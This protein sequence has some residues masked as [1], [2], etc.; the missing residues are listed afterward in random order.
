MTIELRHLRGFLAIAEEGNLTRAAARLH[1]TQ[2]ALSRTLQQLEAHLGVRLV[3]RS[4]H[5]L[6]LT[7][8]GHEFRR[9]AAAAIAAVEHALDPDRSRG[10]PIRL[11]HAWSA[12]GAY[13]T[14][15]QRRWKRAHPETVLELLRLDE[16]S[17]G[18]ASGA[19]DV[20]VLRGPAGVPDVPGVTAT[21]L[22][23]EPRLAAVA[24]D[25]PLAG[26]A[27]LTL[28]DLAS[29]PLALN[30]VT[31][32]TT[33][34]LWPPGGAPSQV[35]PVKNTDDWLAVI[36]AGDAVGVTAAGTAAMHPNP[37]VRYLPLTDAPPV[38]VILAWREPVTHPAVPDLLRLAHDVVRR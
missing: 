5:H 4:T 26:R 22:M 37:A 14:V 17:A 32:S 38:D 27:A 23:R 20:A 33:L 21:H 16:R 28:A 8:A 36:I 6:A 13:T 29:L 10:L 31:G 7:P 35:V 30:T 11:G 1:L 34:A 18:L 2:P 12:L 9:N 24:D 15:L 25:S 3:D 19:V